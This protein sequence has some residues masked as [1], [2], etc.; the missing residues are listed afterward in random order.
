MLCE[1][2]VNPKRNQPRQEEHCKLK[3]FTFD[4]VSLVKTYKAKLLI[5]MNLTLRVIPILQ[6][7]RDERYFFC[8][9]KTAERPRKLFPRN[10]VYYFKTVM[11]TNKYL[12]IPFPHL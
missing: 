10:Q 12:V 2:Q 11:C 9:C 8:A 1:V 6:H 3:C 7:A 4:I 5:L